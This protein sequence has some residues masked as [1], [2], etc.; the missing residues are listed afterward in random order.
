MRTYDVSDYYVRSKIRTCDVSGCDRKFRAKGLCNIHYCRL[1]DNGTLEKAQPRERRICSIDGCG[2]KYSTRGF[3]KLHYHR[4]WMTGKIQPLERDIGKICDVEGCDED[5][6]AKG[7]CGLHSKR[8]K[9]I[10]SFDLPPPRTCDLDGCDKKHCAEGL[11]H[12]HYGRK[13]KRALMGRPGGSD[14]RVL[15]SKEEKKLRKAK[16]D[17]RY[18][19]DN[20]EH[21][22][23]RYTIWY[24]NNRESIRD[25]THIYRLTCA[26]KEKNRL[27]GVVSRG[28]LDD[29]YVK[30]L[31]GFWGAPQQLIELK[32]TQLRITRELRK[33]VTTP[34]N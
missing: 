23:E 21:M 12:M 29:N 17:R 25:K 7:I 30:R 8:M 26:A 2:K 14:D 9:R 33:M 16:G 4:L 15:L 11:C 13:W 19:V 28:D 24:R 10:G 3:C 32:R 27:R 20:I 5:A 6:H 22:K 31:L 34:A 1:R 18:R